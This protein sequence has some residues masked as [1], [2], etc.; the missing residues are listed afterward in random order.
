MFKTKYKALKAILMKEV[1]S[2]KKTALLCYITRLKDEQEKWA[3]F[4]FKYS[5]Q[6]ENDRVGDLA[7]YEKQKYIFGVI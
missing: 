2:P 7:L 3:G 1:K 4:L 6:D 5:T